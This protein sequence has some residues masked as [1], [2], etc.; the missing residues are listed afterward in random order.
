MIKARPAAAARA[1]VAG[2]DRGLRLVEVE[3]KSSFGD[4]RVC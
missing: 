1:A 4:D 2:G 3:A